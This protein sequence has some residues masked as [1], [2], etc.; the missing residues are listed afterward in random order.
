[1]SLL[2]P[3]FASD[4]PS[5]SVLKSTEAVKKKKKERRLSLPTAALWQIN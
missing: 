5:K 4:L 2:T 1:M 3:N